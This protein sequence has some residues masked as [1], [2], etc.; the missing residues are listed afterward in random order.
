MWLSRWNR[1]AAVEKLAD[2][3]PASG[4]AISAGDVLLRDLEGNWA[5]VAIS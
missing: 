5:A 2:R 1:A 3:R 4:A